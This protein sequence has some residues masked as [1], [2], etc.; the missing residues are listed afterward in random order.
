VKQIEN[1]VVALGFL[2]E[3]GIPLRTCWSQPQ[4]LK[5]GE[6]EVIFRE[7]TLILAPG[8]YSIILGLSIYGISFQYVENVAILKIDEFSKNV[9]FNLY[10]ITNSGFIL[11]SLKISFNSKKFR[12]LNEVL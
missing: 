3:L 8:N 9:D 5:P 11:N 12:D 2:T 10:K 6:Y 4:F 7:E 1:L